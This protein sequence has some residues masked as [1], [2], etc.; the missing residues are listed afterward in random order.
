MSFPQIFGG[1]P[2]IAQN[3]LIVFVVVDWIPDQSLRE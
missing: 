1:N 2:E 3:W